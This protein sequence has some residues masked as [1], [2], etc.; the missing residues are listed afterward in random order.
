MD[1][2]QFLFQKLEKSTSPPKITV[3]PTGKWD[4]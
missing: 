1:F 4:L 2:E 3:K